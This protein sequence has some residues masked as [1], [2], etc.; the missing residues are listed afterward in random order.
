[1]G[2]GILSKYLRGKEEV[3]SYILAPVFAKNAEIASAIIKSLCQRVNNDASIY[4]DT[5]NYYSTPAKLVTDLGFEEVALIKRLSETGKLEG[6]NRGK[7]AQQVY[8]L[9]SHGYAP[10]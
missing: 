10:F 1:M 2:Y 7:T 9:S 4:L 6:V 5:L 8:V 3:D